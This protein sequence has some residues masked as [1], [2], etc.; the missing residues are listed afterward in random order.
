MKLLTS[1]IAVALLATLWTIST[2][3]RTHR[4]NDLITTGKIPYGPIPNVEKNYYSYNSLHSAFNS[5]LDLK[6][7][8]E[9]TRFEF[10]EL[11]LGSLSSPTYQQNL[12]KYLSQ[13]LSFS[14]DYQ[15]DPFW[16]ISVMMVESG[17]NK[18]AQSPKNAR[19]LMQIKPDTAQHLYQLMNKKISDEQIQRNLHHPDENIEMGVF[20]LKKLLQNFRLNYHH[21]TIA[22]NLG[23]NK[24]K[25]L[26]DYDEIDTVNYSYLLKVQ[27]RYNE[28]SKNFSDVL[29]KRP[30]PFE[31]TFVVKGQ[32][33][34]LEEQLLGLFVTAYPSIEADFLL[35]SE[36]LAHFYSK[37]RAF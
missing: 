17:F 2:T 19:G 16:I 6:R 10:K 30:K 12:N 37:T 26:L 31:S 28:I 27:D 8:Q 29:K 15:L 33:R 25:S 4:L 5:A 1:V 20:Y 11:I 3:V 36:N 32:G 18:T 23:P 24:L 34:K 7:A 35:S 21:S 13:I 14:E 22:Y 9:F